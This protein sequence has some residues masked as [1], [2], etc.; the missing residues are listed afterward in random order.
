MPSA[1]FY[2]HLLVILPSLH[3]AVR[4]STKE[5][6]MNRHITLGLT[7]VGGIAIGAFA[8]QAI[9]AQAKPPAYVIAEN[10]VNDE[11]G[12][13]KD[14]IPPITKAIEAAGAKYLA[15]GGKAIAMH[16]ALTA[17]RVVVLQFESLDKAQAW[18]NSP[19][20]KAAFAIGDKYATFHDFAVEGVSP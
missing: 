13:T 7:L 11:A 6:A 5:H 15:R 8:V 17:N 4:P 12:Y 20:T 1:S 16:G 18:W 14:F 2:F 9:H 19:A 10:I 3:A